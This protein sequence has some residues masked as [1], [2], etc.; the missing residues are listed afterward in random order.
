[1]EFAANKSDHAASERQNTLMETII[2]K[3]QTEIAHDQ[4]SAT[5][6]DDAVRS[7]QGHDVKWIEANLGKWMFTYFQHDGA[8]VLSPD[9]KLVYGF[10]TDTSDEAA[11]FRHVRDAALPLA[12]KLRDRLKATDTEGISD[13]VLSIGESDVS[14][15]NGHPAIVSVKPIVSDTGNVAQV[16]G[17][18]FLHVAVRYL[19]GSLLSGVARDYQF[20]D[21][22]FTW[23]KVPA[24]GRSYTGLSTSAGKTFGYLTWK[25][26]RPGAYVANE[27]R[28]AIIGAG[29]TIFL[30]VSFLSSA[31]LKRSRRLATSQA[32]LHHLAGHDVLTGLANRATFNDKL[33]RTIRSSSVSQWNAVLFLDLDR[34][35]QVNDT[36]GHPV[37]DRVIVEV[38]RRLES[39]LD[40]ALI[41]RIGGDEFTVILE[42]TSQVAIEAVSERVIDMIGKPFEINGHPVTIGVSIGVALA[43][44]S[45]VDALDLT[46]KADIALYHSKT[47]GRNRF[48]IFGSHMDELVQSR[49]ML[50]LDLR[51]A[52]QEGDQ[53]EVQ[54]QPVYDS[55][56]RLLA[57]VEALLR[58]HHP[59]R[60]T[61]APEVFIPMAEEIGLIE[62]IGNFVIEDAC[63]TAARWP[64]IDVAVNASAIELKSE[65]YVIRVL[66]ALNRHGVEPHRLEIEL[67]ESALMDDS[68]KCIGNIAALRALGIRV[69]LDDFGTGFSSLGR[70]RNMD[71][72]R[73]KIDKSFVDNCV[74][75]GGNPAIVRAMIGLAHAKGLRTTAEG[76][77]TI[78]QRE[79]LRSLGC[80][81]L[82]GY[83]LSRPLPK[84]QLNALLAKSQTD[85]SDG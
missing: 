58:W 19:D 72:D 49:R 62:R 4:E 57:S 14:I 77:E 52:V 21:L 12:S 6:W 66:A 33:D 80:D 65:S 78:E 11:A 50:E 69:A 76:V 37:G 17:T 13:Q 29:A 28:P 36:L 30:I 1:L 79:L 3:L 60:G 71:V 47:S 38:A 10:S 56:T 31:I 59:E 43:Q 51:T 53:F 82:Q 32:K 42:N 44:G 64:T 22:R 41:A 70:L 9:D 15:V 45:G 83:L 61:I 74:S 26:F 46:R 84:A 67:T 40:R 35:K 24:T 39:V 27:T 2:S 25:P 73:I 48:A 55:D 85:A 34:F 7:V 18:E 75:V 8:F 16:P 63:A 54:Y 5:V 81:Q 20:D 68:G 23:S